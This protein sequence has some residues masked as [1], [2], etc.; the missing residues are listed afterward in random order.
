MKKTNIRICRSII[1]LGVFTLAYSAIAWAGGSLEVNLVYPQQ[2]NAVKREAKKIDKP[3][4][5]EGQVAVNVAGLDPE[6]LKHAGAYAEYFMDDRLIYSSV[7]K[8]PDASGRILLGCTLYTA[9]YPDGEHTLLVNFWD[10]E[11]P[12]AI[13]ARK[14][15]IQNV[16]NKN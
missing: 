5:L 3:A 12:S 8:K 15:I 6:Q 1:I 14:I 7:T 9:E 16:K 4:V 11:G 2:S 10:K 13:G